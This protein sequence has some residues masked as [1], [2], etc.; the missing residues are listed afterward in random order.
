[1]KLMPSSN[2][3]IFTIGHSNHA[4]EHFLGLLAQHE[5]AVLADIRRFPGSRLLPHFNQDAFAESL[6]ERGIT[7]R[8]IE[9]L[10]GRRRKVRDADEPSPNLGLRNQSFRNYADYMM[11]A[12]F[13]G[14]FD[15][16]VTLAESQRTAMMCSESVF[17]RCHRRLVSDYVLARGGRVHHIFPAGEVKPHQLTSAGR[18]E[19]GGV[20]YP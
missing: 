9:A 18:L 8:W 3:E 4:L 10:G 15:E 14:G 20:R 2:L 13:R 5:I 12:E 17:W 11:T 19:N 1:M 7:Y 6:G 16:L